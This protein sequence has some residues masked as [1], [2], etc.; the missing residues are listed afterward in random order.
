MNLCEGIGCK[1]YVVSKH[2]NI[3]FDENQV[4][5]QMYVALTLNLYKR[6]LFFAI[7]NFSKHL[8]KTLL[9]HLNN[10]LTKIDTLCVSCQ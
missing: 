9:L 8:G 5:I 2:D 3:Y 7:T 4:M 1:K 10:L 6:N